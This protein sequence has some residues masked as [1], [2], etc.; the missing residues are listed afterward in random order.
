MA[1]VVQYLPSKHKAL[2]SNPSTNTKK[3][4]RK[5]KKQ[6]NYKKPLKIKQTVTN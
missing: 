6:N 1:Q 4:K 5:K 3:K 2:I